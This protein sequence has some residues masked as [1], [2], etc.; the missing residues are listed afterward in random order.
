MTTGSHPIP[1]PS[2]DRSLTDDLEDSEKTDRD[3]INRKSRAELTSDDR[4][5]SDVGDQEA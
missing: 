4:P 3:G 1:T 5:R 2:Y